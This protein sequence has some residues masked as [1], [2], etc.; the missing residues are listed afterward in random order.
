MPKSQ[1][2]RLRKDMQII[3]Q[4][5]FSS[6]NPRMT[7]GSIISEPLKIHGLA[8]GRGIRTRLNELLQ[9]VGLE[10]AYAS[11]YPHEFSGGQRQRVGIARAL[12]GEPKFIVADE[13]VS[14]LD[15]S[16]QAQIV[17]LLQALQQKFSLAYLFI[18]HD[19]SVIKHLSRRVAIM[20]LGKLVEVGVAGEVYDK[21]LHP[22]TE[23]LL[24]AIPEA[25]IRERR[26]RIVLPGDVPNPANPPAGCVFHP[27]CRYAQERCRQE[28][29]V[30]T[31]SLRQVAC[32][33]PL[34]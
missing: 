1:L 14:A 5:P 29:P 3:F 19:L 16:I 10:P 26:N 25:G 21:P 9:L 2:R 27:R 34:G 32:F 30:L 7:I 12:A 11:R 13:P 8:T 33:Y 6:L 17:N 31:G 4:D 24:S 22:Y 18:S 28:T 23:A 15:V 20:Y